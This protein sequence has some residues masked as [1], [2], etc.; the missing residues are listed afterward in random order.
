MTLA[1]HLYCF[2]EPVTLTDHAA[3]AAGQLSVCHHLAELVAA[4][5]STA[6]SVSV[7]PSQSCLHLLEDGEAKHHA[8]G[9]KQ[10]GR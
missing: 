8:P 3:A 2:R 6:A 7:A 10:E 5:V 4:L 9:N 1:D